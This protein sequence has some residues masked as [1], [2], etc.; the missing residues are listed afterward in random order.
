MRAVQLRRVF[1]LS[2]RLVSRARLNQRQ[3]VCREPCRWYT[4]PAPKD[5]TPAALELEIP[6]TAPQSGT[7]R[8]SESVRRTSR[9]KATST[10]PLVTR[11]V[12]KTTVEP[13]GLEA[14][15]AEAD[16]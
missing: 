2:V 5:P 14:V 13:R 1:C 16:G 9:P 12:C 3:R 15:E 11:F 7:R 6:A 4:R 10:A 8:S